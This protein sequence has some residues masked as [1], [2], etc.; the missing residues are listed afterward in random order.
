MIIYILS[1]YRNFLNSYIIIDEL[2]NQLN[3]I[4][5][6]LLFIMR[7]IHSNTNYILKQKI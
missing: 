5:N 7:E 6:R 1:R 3:N 4:Y 2:F